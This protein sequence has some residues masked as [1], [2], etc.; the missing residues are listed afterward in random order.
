MKSLHRKQWL[1]S[2][3]ILCIPVPL[4]AGRD[5]G[6]L[7]SF[8]KWSK[9]QVDLVG[10]KSLGRSK[11]ANPFLIEV[12]VTFSGPNGAR[13]TVPAFYDETEAAE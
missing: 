11:I 13:Y 9:L 8:A 1:L 3:I 6:H 7:G 2:L 10:P 12:T 4:T 5:L